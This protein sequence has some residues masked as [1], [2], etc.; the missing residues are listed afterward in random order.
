MRTRS[1]A[2]TWVLR[3]AHRACA[4]RSPQNTRVPIVRVCSG[5]HPTPCPPACRIRLHLAEPGLRPT[6][7]RPAAH[8]GGARHAALRR[9]PRP[10]QRQPPV[11]P[12]RHVQR[13]QTDQVVRTGR[14]RA[15]VATRAHMFIAFLARPHPVSWRRSGTDVQAL[16]AP[17]LG[18]S[19]CLVCSVPPAVRRRRSPPPRRAPRPT[20]ATATA[21]RATAATAARRATAQAG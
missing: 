3:D 14:P 16:D 15:V 7:R 4:Q 20:T 13:L 12:G 2:L 6:R 19:F 21:A 1:L 10:Y 5:L 11:R 17:R 9:L 8:P 18:F